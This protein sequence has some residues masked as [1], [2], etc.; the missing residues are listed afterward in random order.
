MNKRPPE[1]SRTVRT[2]ENVE[3]VRQALL[4][5]PS[6]SARRHSSELGLSSRSLRRILHLDLH[7]HPYKLV[8][9]QQLK[10]GDYAQRVTFA[11]EMQAIFQHN[12]NLILCMSDEARF[13][14]NGMVNQQNCRYWASEN[15][16]QLHG[17]RLHRPKVTVWCAMGKIGVIGSY[18]FEEDNGNAVNVN[19]ERYIEMINNFFWIFYKSRH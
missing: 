10:P 6:R 3:R 11:H 16:K 1:A 15:P 4:R 8:V 18:F 13:H 19:S 17:R 5:S 2:P 9:V 14:L 7:F 12:D